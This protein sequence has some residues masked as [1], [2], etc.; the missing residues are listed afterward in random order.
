MNNPFHTRR[1]DRERGG[2]NA[3]PKP[4]N[5][6]SLRMLHCFQKAMHALEL[7]RSSLRTDEKPTGGNGILWVAPNSAEHH[8]FFT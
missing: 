2:E 8:L 3:D 1:A 4:T 6:G 7:C 5:P